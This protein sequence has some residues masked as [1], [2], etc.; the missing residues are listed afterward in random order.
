MLR[1]LLWEGEDE[2]QSLPVAS[3]VR[4][5]AGSRR[6]GDPGPAS[7]QTHGPRSQGALA[8]HYAAARG[9]LECVKL[10]LDSSDQFR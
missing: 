2:P 6:S 4:P 3:E 7:L 8:L 1:W 5:R 10:I 9:C